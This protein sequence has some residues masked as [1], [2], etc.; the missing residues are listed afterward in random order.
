MAPSRNRR[1]RATKRP[2]GSSRNEQHKHPK[3]AV[4][5]VFTRK[6]LDERAEAD[7]DVSDFDDDIVI[8]HR[9]N[10][11]RNDDN[12]GGDVMV[13]GD[14][15]ADATY[16]N[17]VHGGPTT[18][19]TGS[20]IIVQGGGGG[21][22]NGRDHLNERLV[23]MQEAMNEL[24]RELASRDAYIQHQDAKYK[25]VTVQ[26]VGGSFVAKKM[27]D[28]Q[29]TSLSKFVKSTLFRKVKLVTNSVLDETPN[30]LKDCYKCLQVE[31]IN[32]QGAIR[33][34]LITKLKA[35]L[36]ARRKYVK[37]RLKLVYLGEYM[38]VSCLATLVVQMRPAI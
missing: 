3:I 26:S 37:N 28:E 10:Q 12:P 5:A 4:E 9:N 24:K 1:G 13:G 30:I 8:A 33:G 7:D 14:D 20:R 38:L 25:K 6:R 2:S 32:D 17:V 35:I 19:R 36:S 16:Q 18:I 23:R 27:S 21:H 22:D 15:E 31:D 29:V 34:S 11:V